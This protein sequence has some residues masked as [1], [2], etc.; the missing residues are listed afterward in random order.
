[1]TKLVY[2][3]GLNDADYV[4]SSASKGKCPYYYRW[5][6]MLER[7]YSK[8]FKARFPTYV[9]CVV[10][11]EWLTFSNF[12]VWMEQ[13]DWEGKHLDKD[14]LGD[15]KLYSPETCCFIG[16]ALNTFLSKRYGHK[17][18]TGVFFSKVNKRFQAQCGNPMTGKPT[19]CGQYDTPEEAH[20]AWGK[21][22]LEYAGVVTK[23]Y[24]S[25]I[26][27]AVL[28]KYSLKGEL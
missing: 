15:G 5:L 4:T 27:D 25:Y 20:E 24:P 26:V 16:V 13:Q 17:Y 22:K 19:Y 6:S 18:P 8:K 10:C 23:G 12:K 3:I 14:I 2:G 7:C 9:G 1:V 11:E 28:K 21:K